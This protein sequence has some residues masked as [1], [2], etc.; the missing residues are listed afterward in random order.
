[1]AN[2]C[3]EQPANLKLVR[4]PDLTVQLQE[5]L[6]DRQARGLSPKTLK[7]YRQSLGTLNA[8]LLDHGV[9]TLSN[10][11]PATLRAFLVHLQQG[12]NPGGIRNIFGAVRA[13]LAWY[14]DENGLAD[15]WAAL[16]KVKMPKVPEQTL[17]PVSLPDLQKMLATCTGRNFADCRDRAILLCLLDTGCRA[18]EFLALDLADVDLGTGAVRVRRGKGGKSRV[19]FVGAKA[20][21]ALLA[22]LRYRGNADGPL[23]VAADGHGLT[24]AGLRQVVRRRATKA[25]VPVPGLHSFRRAFAIGCLRGGVDLESLRRL[26]GHADLSIIRRYLAQTQEDLQTA[27]RRGSPVDNWL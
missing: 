25:G 6:T 1:M 3:N 17:P 8:Y 23:W 26:L 12:H 18:S 22:Y 27:H 19:T 21:K 11:S 4:H 13:L 15:W 24:F 5:F 7:W 16:R 2:P 14:A 20:R 9:T 10:L